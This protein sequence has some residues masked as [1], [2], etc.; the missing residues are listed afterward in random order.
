MVRDVEGE[1]AGFFITYPDYGRLVN[2]QAIE[3]I[4]VR[5]TASEI[6]YS[7]HYSLLKP[8][9]LLLAKTCGVAQKYRSA[10]L[11]PLMS[12]QLSLWAKGYY[13]QVSAAMIRD[14]NASMSFHTS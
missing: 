8:P 14:D 6:N 1:I 13:E 10:K 11:F 12:M 5:L 7:D 2:Q 3:E 4:G 9:R